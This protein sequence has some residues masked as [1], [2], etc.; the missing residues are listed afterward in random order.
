MKNILLLIHDDAGQEARLQAGLDLARALRGHLRCLDLVLNPSKMSD[1][2]G[3]TTAYVLLLEEA[4]ERGA[5]NRSRTMSRLAKEDVAWSMESMSGEPVDCVASICGLCDV[6]VVSSRIADPAAR[7][8]VALAHDVVMKCGKPVLAVP[9]SCR[10]VDTTGTALVAWD[11]SAPAAEALAAAVPL[12]KLASQVRILSVDTRGGAADCLEAA[13]Y[14]SKHDVHADVSMIKAPGTS[15]SD[16]ILDTCSEWDA[17]LCV[18]GA[19]GHARLREALFGGVTRRML[20][21]APIPLLL[22]H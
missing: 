2:F 17:A 3:D 19:Y 20:A 16:A 10:A 22:A 13:T 9:E 15:P 4:R 18:M 8:M 11:G 12:L 7:D 6:V 1:Y 21:E 14:L 5:V